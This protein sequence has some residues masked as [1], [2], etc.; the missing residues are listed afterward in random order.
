[1]SKVYDVLIIGGGPAGLTAGIYAGRAKLST[2]ILE[3]EKVGGQIVTTDEVENYPGSVEDPSGPK[4]IARMT[5]QFEGF[6]GELAMEQVESFDFDSK[7]KTVK[8]NKN[9]YQAK[10]VII[11]TGAGPRKLEAKNEEKYVGKGVSFCATC[12]AAFFEGLD[13]Y[14]VGGGDTA[15]EEAVFIT[16]FA[17][18]VTIIHRRD[19][20]RAA[21]SI[22]E[23]A[24]NNDKIEFMWD[25]VVEE[26]DGEGLLSQMT[27]LNR[28][29]GERT[30]IK[31][32]E[33]DGTFGIFVMIGYVPKTD[34]F[35]GVLE[36]DQSGYI[37]GDE[38]MKTNKEGV[39][40]AGDCRQKNLRQ[41][42]TATSDGAIASINAEKYIEDA[43]EH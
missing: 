25:S 23:K 30:V 17:K 42:V 14:V 12:D 36:M 31:A 20:L 9:E 7:I 6:G 1:M 38:N 8:T 40:V 3:G 19:E 24:F 2:I 37:I 43:F 29:T 21:K 4:L 13:V 39:F 26:V 28:K 22:Q 5:E 41:V 35:K 11:A 16:K 10:S 27:V 34:L 32:D 18:K 33:N 15:V